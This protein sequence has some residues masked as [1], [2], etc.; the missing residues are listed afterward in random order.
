M[1]NTTTQ[2]TAKGKKNKDVDAKVVKAR[3]I[4]E[5]KNIP[6]LIFRI[7]A[8][9]KDLIKLSSRTKKNFGVKMST[10]RDFRLKF[11][12]EEQQQEEEEMEAAAENDE[13]SYTGAWS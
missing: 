4:R 3:V 11:Q 8:F 12:Q 13:V 1:K 6:N 2:N 5:T 7:E 9:E 10:S